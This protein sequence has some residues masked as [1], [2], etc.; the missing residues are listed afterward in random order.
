MPSSIRTMGLVLTLAGIPSVPLTGQGTTAAALQEAHVLYERLEV[1]RALLLLRQVVSPAWTAEVSPAQRVE[2]YT[3]LGAALA[4]AGRR[5]SAVAGFRTALELDPFTDLNPTL[6]TP[7]QLDAFAAARRA[8]FAIGVRPVA[9]QRV[10]PRTQRVFF[11]AATTHATTLEVA[12][13]RLG[14]PDHGDSVADTTAARAIVYQGSVE[15]VRQFSWDGLLADGRLAPTGRYELTVD[16]TSEL[17]ARADT[18]RVFFDLRQV[19]TGLEDTLPDLTDLLPT[20]RPGQAG[21][22][23][24]VKGLAV[25]VAAVAIGGRLGN[26]DLGNGLKS[27]ATIVAGTATVTGLVSFLRARRHRTLPENVAQNERRLAERRDANAAIRDR[28]TQRLAAT[29]I[30]VAP[31][32]GVGP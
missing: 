12:V 14:A 21:T 1:E 22:G 20:S 18:A 3:Y 9:S 13:R 29:V 28:N 26:H 25:A 30:V 8:V 2:A 27:G 19:T 32:A 10:D 4:L 16:G 5:D 15:G 6:F 11:I 31:A 24:L 17:L 23:E 7:S